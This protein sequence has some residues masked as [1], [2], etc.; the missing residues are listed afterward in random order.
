MDSVPYLLLNYYNLEMKNPDFMKIAFIMLFAF[1]VVTAQSNIEE[2]LTLVKNLP[3]SSKINKLNDFCWKNRSQD[4]NL[5]L[6]SGQEAL[7]IAQR[8]RDIKSQSK[9]LNLIGVVYRNQGNYDIAISSYKKAL[10]LS[11]E[12]EDS[13][14]IAFSKNNI[15]GIYRLQGN[16]SVALKYI[17]DALKI[18][19]RLNDKSGISFCTIN[20]GI[21]YWRQQNYNKALDYLNYTLRI[22][23]EIKDMPGGAL[24]LNLIAEVH[25][26]LADIE[27]AL[28]YYKQV[29]KKYEEINNKKGLADAWGGL[30][31]VYYYKKSYKLALEYRLR[32]LRMANEIS[33]LEGQIT[34]YNNIGRIYAQLKNYKEAEHSFN[35]AL[36]LAA[37]TEII[38]SQIECYKYLAEYNEIKKDYKQSLIYAWKYHTL[39]DSVL[40]FQNS[41]FISQMESDYQVEKIKRQNDLLVKDLE[42]NIKQRNYLFIIAALVIGF[43]V[44]LYYFYQLKRRANLE[45]RNLNAM[46]DKFFGI[47]A[48]DLRSPFNTLFGFTSIL[49]DDYNKIDDYER[50]KLIKNIEDSGKQAYRLLENLL[51]WAQSQTDRLKI[52]IQSVDLREIVLETFSVLKETAG[53]KQITLNTTVEENSFVSCDEDMIKTVL[54]NLVTNA[55]KFSFHNNS[56]TVSIEDEENFKKICIEDNGTG[57][58]DRIKEKI[59]S[60]ESVYT[61]KGTDGESGTGLGLIICKEFVEKNGGK[62]WF[63]SNNG[64]GTK[65]YFTVPQK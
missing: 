5:A 18:F 23:E 51:N 6:L 29:E 17:L 22:R 50:K 41:A 35:R 44:V 49:R 4:P 13:A 14:Q 45:L 48:H 27:T 34:N 3:D 20:I 33:Y 59:F 58:D 30:G 53:N 21:I 31:K 43:T 52:N 2:L 12:A 39:R 11:E 62:I 46:K 10:R 47:I 65:F 26:D 8:I 7:K 64:K 37:K 54:R 55:I 25:F 24:A 60:L 15:G 1:S 63:E 38:D 19:E 40:N 36:N 61:S 16:Y 28:E 32:A 42:L 57:I 9:S 56:V